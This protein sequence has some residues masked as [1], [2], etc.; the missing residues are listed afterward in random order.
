[1]PWTSASTGGKSGD[2][3]TLRAGSPD[4]AVTGLA[5]C[6]VVAADSEGIAEFADELLRSCPE[7]TVLVT[8]RE[9]INVP[10]EITWQVPPLGTDEAL[11]LFAERA[12]AVL[13]YFA[14]DQVNE[15]A[16]RS[17]CIHLYGIPSRSNSHLLQQPLQHGDDVQ[18]PALIARGQRGDPAG[19]V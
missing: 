17:M 8:S 11:S 14:V 4:R 1:M 13:P 9:P 5:T 2:M 12:A 7:L 10:G 19:Q 15:P 18:D 16:I 3:G 6:V